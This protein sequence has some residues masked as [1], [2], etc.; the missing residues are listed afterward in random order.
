MRHLNVLVA[1][2]IAATVTTTTNATDWE[3][4]RPESTQAWS[5]LRKLSAT[6]SFAVTELQATD[7]EPLKEVSRIDAAVL[8][9]QFYLHRTD[10]TSERVGVVGKNHGF[11]LTRRDQEQEWDILRYGPQRQTVL[12]NLD[13]QINAIRCPPL[14]P[15]SK[16]TVEEL[17]AADGLS[18]ISVEETGESEGRRIRLT[19][20]FPDHPVMIRDQPVEAKRMIYEFNPS[21]Y[22]VVTS[23]ELISEHFHGKDSVEYEFDDQQRP[24][25]RKVVSLNKWP[26]AGTTQTIEKRYTKYEYDCPPEV[27]EPA[28]YNLP[29][30]SKGP[31]GQLRK[32]SLFLLAVIVIVTALF[33]RRRVTAKDVL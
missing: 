8:H 6:L 32:V 30:I 24:L 21:R 19:V 5:E 3:T 20:E 26:K 31:V 7:N 23:F 22:W 10:D 2:A 33:I 28:T 11:M 25:L 16:V 15:A 4:Y 12:D 14:T 29:P 18:D 13:D 27:F 9:D 17:L 1:G